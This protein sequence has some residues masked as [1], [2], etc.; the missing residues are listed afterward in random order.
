[1]SSRQSPRSLAHIALILLLAGCSES[2][3]RDYTSPSE[4]ACSQYLACCNTGAAYCNDDNMKNLCG[5]ISRV[6]EDIYDYTFPVPVDVL[7]V[8]DNSQ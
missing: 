5:S 7:F 4:S 3:W 2:V 1:M 8:I 6:S